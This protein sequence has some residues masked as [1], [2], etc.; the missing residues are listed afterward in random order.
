[1]ESTA[2]EV[3]LKR[4]SHQR[5]LRDLDRLRNENVWLKKDVESAHEWGI[6]QGEETRRLSDRLNAVVAAAA[7]C[8]VS[9]TDINDALA[10]ADSLRR[11]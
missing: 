3:V 8:G 4:R 10:H 6:R 9:I 1:M 11:T 2:D 5:L 7:A